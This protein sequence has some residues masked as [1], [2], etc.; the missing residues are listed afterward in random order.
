[1]DE[2]ILIPDLIKKL[3]TKEIVLDTLKKWNITGGGSF[4]DNEDMEANHGLSIYFGSR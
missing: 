4:T 1:E 3:H 2:Q